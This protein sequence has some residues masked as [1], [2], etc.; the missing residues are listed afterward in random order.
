MT[1][2]GMPV[3][4][5]LKDKLAWHQA[6]QRV[7]AENVANADTPGYRARD[8]AEPVMRGGGGGALA[9][10]ATDPGHFGAGGGA[11]FDRAVSETF[12]TKPAGNSVVLEEEVLKV[13]QNAMD[14]QMVADL[15]GRSL[16]LL[17][18]AAIRR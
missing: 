12:E 4:G 11:G 17:R 9:L 7:L 13:G 14:H 1:I 3:L 10:A 18:K 5:F 16:G 15:Y 2:A 6:R 8:I